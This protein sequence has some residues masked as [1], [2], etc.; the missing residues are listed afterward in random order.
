MK[1]HKK[2]VIRN[3]LEEFEFYIWNNEWEFS[4][5]NYQKVVDE[6]YQAIESEKPDDVYHYVKDFLIKNYPFHWEYK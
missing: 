2:Q 3:L 4:E 1:E 6:L 5:N